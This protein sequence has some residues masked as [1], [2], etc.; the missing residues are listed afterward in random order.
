[1]DERYDEMVVK[2]K[3]MIEFGNADDFYKTLALS[4]DDRNE[5]VLDF[6][7]IRDIIDKDSEYIMAAC[8][9]L[10]QEGTVVRLKDMSLPVRNRFLLSAIDYAGDEVIL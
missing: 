3:D 4:V 6:N 1:M 9:R 2:M 8:L 7:G 10:K 5:V